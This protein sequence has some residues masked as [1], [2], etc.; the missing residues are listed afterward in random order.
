MIPCLSDTEPGFRV[1]DALLFPDSLIQEVTRL[2]PLP[3]SVGFCFHASFLR[4]LGLDYSEEIL[5][6]QPR[7]S[8]PFLLKTNLVIPLPSATLQERADLIIY[9]VDPLFFQKMDADW[10]VELQQ[11]ILKQFALQR[12]R[13]VDPVTGLYNQRALLAGPE[14]P[15]CWKALFFV[16]TVSRRRTVTGRYQAVCSTATLLE[17][18]TGEPVFCFGQGVFGFLGRPQDHKEACHFARRLITR[19]KREKL[20]RIHIGFSLFGEVELREPVLN[21]CWEALAEAERRGPYSLCDAASLQQSTQHPFALPEAA[22]LRRIQRKWCGVDKFGLALFSC[23]NGEMVALSTMLHEPGE[24]SF[25]APGI[26]QFVVF[27]DQTKKQTAVRIDNII[28][29]VQKSSGQS[30]AVGY[31]AWPNTIGS[32][33]VDC[34]RHCRKAIMHGSFYGEDAIVACDSLTFNVSGDLY[35]DEGDYKR[36]LKEYRQGLIMQPGEVNLLNSLGVALAGVGR[37]R[38][39][40]ECFSR[41]LGSLPDNH[42]ALVN[43][44]MSCRLIG[45]YASAVQ[46]F[47]VALSSPDHD[48]QTT[49]EHYLQLGRLYCQAEQYEQAVDLLNSWLASRDEPEEFMFFRIIGEACLGAGKNREAICFLQRSLQLYPHNADSLSMLGLLYVLEGEGEEVGLSLCDK[50]IQM[51]ETESAHL[52]R[53]AEVLFYLKRYTEALALVRQVVQQQK[54]NDRAVLLRAEIYDKIGHYRKARQSY[55]RV[56]SMNTAGRKCLKLAQ[57]RLRKLKN[58][59]KY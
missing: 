15:S 51:D 27:A 9:D 12:L 42:M 34:L 46:C 30:I 41:V 29:E 10:L 48:E 37:H 50:A 8:R 22:V 36:A 55:Q 23:Q 18:V 31:C 1:F 13:Y 49:L 24:T 54:N 44:A 2:L 26:G 14:E 4:Q 11:G 47:E 32:S 59:S 3:A 53:K 35:L 6:S 43:K 39:A 21:R 58:T 33:K 16:A 45:D 40:I 20:S 52:Y 17:A 56:L 38:Q 7:Q 25:N 28:K 5:R 19:L 57:Q